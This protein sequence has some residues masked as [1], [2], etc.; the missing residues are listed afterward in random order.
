MPQRWLPR[1]AA[2]RPAG[3]SFAPAC[4]TLRRFWRIFSAIRGEKQDWQQPGNAAIAYRYLALQLD[5]LIM[6]SEPTGAGGNLSPRCVKVS[7]S[8]RHFPAAECWADGGITLRAA[9]LLPPQAH[10][11][12]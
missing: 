7:Q 12:W 2:I 9:R 1:L 5:A 3:F 6:T 10:S 4:K 11:I 8:R